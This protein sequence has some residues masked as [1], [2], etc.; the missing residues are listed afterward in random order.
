MMGWLRRLA[1]RRPSRGTVQYREALTVAQ[2]RR[3]MIDRDLDRR[4][5]A[6]TRS[7]LGN[8][9]A[10]RDDHEGAGP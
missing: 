4:R 6:P 8:V 5:E 2:G 1:W 3:Q 9:I 10:D 7:I